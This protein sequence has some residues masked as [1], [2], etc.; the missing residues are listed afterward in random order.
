MKNVPQLVFDIETVSKDFESF[1]A[2]SKAFLESRFKKY[3]GTP[4][5]IEEEKG[6]LTFSPLTAEIVAIGM[7]D[8]RTRKGACYFQSRVDDQPFEE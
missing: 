5:E 4:E 8:A 6:R 7:A 1:D 3:A 2:K